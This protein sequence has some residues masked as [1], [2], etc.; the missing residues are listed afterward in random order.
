MDKK[1]SFKGIF[2][3]M[4]LTLA[5]ASL[6]N[7]LPM[8]KDTIHLILDPTLGKLLELH[9]TWGM[10]GM[11]FLI[12]LATT[13]IQKYATD[14]KRIKEMKEE[15]KKMSEEAKKYK[16]HPEKL[17]EMNKKQMEFMGEMMRYSMRP[18]IYT[19]IPLVLLFRWFLDY[20]SVMPEFKFFGVL[21]WFWMYLLASIIF[22]TIL[23]KN[24]KVA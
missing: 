8:I 10:I 16:E 18:I 9:L 11:V 15:Q 23:R 4:L 6:W 7:T 13:L 12:S 2:I 17:L 24:F 22:S 3:V 14:Q 21:S 1:G 19:G 5:I 20:F